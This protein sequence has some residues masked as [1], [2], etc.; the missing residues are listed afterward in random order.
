MRMIRSWLYYGLMS[1]SLASTNL[2]SDRTPEGELILGDMLHKGPSSKV[3]AATLAG[4]DVVVKYENDCLG[5]LNAFSAETLYSDSH[6]LIHEY[7]ILERLKASGVFPNPIFLSEA[8]PLG[9]SPRYMSKLTDIS[10]GLCL[11]SGTLVRFLVEEKVGTDVPTFLRNLNRAPH[12]KTGQYTDMAVSIII[13][14]I[15][16]LEK[17]HGA[18]FVHGDI[19]MKNIACKSSAF[20]IVLLDPQLAVDVSGEGTRIPK[21]GGRAIDGMVGQYLSVWQLQGYAVRPRDDIYRALMTLSVML[22]RAKMYQATSTMTNGL[23]KEAKIEFLLDIHNREPFFGRSD[24]L[25]SEARIGCDVS[26]D[27]ASLVQERLDGIMR[28]VRTA[29]DGEEAKPI[30]YAYIVDWLEETRTLLSAKDPKET[31]F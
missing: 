26:A 21:N 23:T 2:P 5:R 9:P 6:P 22:S 8:F 7:D 27:L 11:T 24:R 3:F 4:R 25:N 28:L 19:H 20:E 14:A 15:W 17:L 10:Y 31:T 29:Y 30:D 13:G 1:G 12:G 18:G 16:K